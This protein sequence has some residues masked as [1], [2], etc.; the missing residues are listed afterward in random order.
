MNLHRN[1]LATLLVATSLSSVA[2][3]AYAGPLSASIPLRDAM[4]Q[5]VETVQWRGGAWRGGWGGG[6]RGG[7]GGGSRGGWGG[8][9]LGLAAGAIL[10]SAVLRQWLRLRLLFSSILRRLLCPDLLPLR[11]RRLRT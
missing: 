3:G 10:F 9:G 4:S 7:L 2:G 5:S 8:V 11:R 6:W 1:A